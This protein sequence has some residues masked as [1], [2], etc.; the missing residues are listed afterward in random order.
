VVGRASG[1]DASELGGTVVNTT[2][3]G[4]AFLG[5]FASCLMMG[6]RPLESANWA[7]LAGAIK[8]TKVETRGS[9]AKRELES[10]MKR[11]DKSRRS[12]LGFR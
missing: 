3:C 2:G 8:A 7:N 1:F 6:R 9:P 11:V 12:A 5:V 4:D 10:V